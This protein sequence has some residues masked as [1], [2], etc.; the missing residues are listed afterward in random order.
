ML[1]HLPIVILAALPV[2]RVADD[3]PKFDIAA[4]CR[5]EGGTQA[6]LSRCT[7]DETDARQQLQAQ[8]AQFKGPERAS[9]IRETV[10][11]G[12]GSYVELLTCLEMARDVR[13]R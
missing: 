2:T 11:D 7:E 1:L 12:T 8:W 4:E 6:V 10:M 13:P 3:V 9:C 5:S